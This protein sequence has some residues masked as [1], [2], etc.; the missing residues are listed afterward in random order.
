MMSYF[1]NGTKK[2]CENLGQWGSVIF[3][4]KAGHGL[5]FGTNKGP[6]ACT[7]PNSFSGKA[8]VSWMLEHKQATDRRSAVACFQDL[9]NDNMV[10]YAD[11][12]NKDTAA[13]A[14]KFADSPTEFYKLNNATI[15]E[16]LGGGTG[17]GAVSVSELASYCMSVMHFNYDLGPRLAVPS[18]LE[19]N[20]TRHCI[21]TNVPIYILNGVQYKFGC[22]SYTTVESMLEFFR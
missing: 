15:T 18:M 1:Y 4:M 22:E 10:V 11:Y 9:M 16:K 3:E 12:A 19:F 21:A 13:A 5:P 20:N 6:K 17:E 7:L 2:G 14:K 8:G